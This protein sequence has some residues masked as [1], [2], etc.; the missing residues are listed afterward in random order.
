MLATWTLPI[1]VVATGQ[2]Q[3][4]LL[5]AGV[6]VLVL[7][8]YTHRSNLARIRAGN[9]SKVGFLARRKA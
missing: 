8:L 9:E 3:P 6:L 1:Y 7:V 4:V 2:T 5:V